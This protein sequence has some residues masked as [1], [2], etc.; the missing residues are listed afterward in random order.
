MTP[1]KRAK[2]MKKKRQ[3]YLTYKDD[4]EYKKKK[5]ESDKK[6]RENKEKK[7]IDKNIIISK[8]LKKM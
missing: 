1:E 5:A 3:D 7:K 4:P 6:Y 2:K 8:Y